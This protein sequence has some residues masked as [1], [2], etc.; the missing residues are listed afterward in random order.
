[1][2]TT[3]FDYQPDVLNQDEDVLLLSA[4]L[5]SGDYPVLLTTLS[6]ERSLLWNQVESDERLMKEDEEHEKKPDDKAVADALAQCRSV[7]Q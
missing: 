2:D 7:R 6:Q 1:M 5:R 3:Y 4:D